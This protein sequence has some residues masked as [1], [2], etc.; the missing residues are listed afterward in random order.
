MNTAVQDSEI[1]LFQ[2]Y[3]EASDV[4]RS[5]PALAYKSVFLTSQL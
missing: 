5:W 4:L 2:L 3:T 1:F